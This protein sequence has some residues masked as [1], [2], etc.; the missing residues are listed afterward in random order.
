MPAPQYAR[1]IPQRYRME[2]SRCRTC[3]KVAFPPRL[4]CSSCRGESFEPVTLPEQGTL[5][6][7]TVVHVAP[8]GFSGQTPY[9]VGIVELGGVRVTA[10]IVDT[11]P[12][13]LAFGVPLR[14]VFRKLGAEGEGGILR[15][16][17]KFVLAE[18]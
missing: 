16:G 2:A 8:R 4:S 10:Q 3:Q 14:R 5:V 7:W 18:G 15:Y 12:R 13:E 11:E 6:T 9:I 1:E 17:Y